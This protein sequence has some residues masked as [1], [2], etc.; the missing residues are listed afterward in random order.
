MQQ[1]LEA[2]IRVE[3]AL[4][5]IESLRTKLISRELR[6]SYF[7]SNSDYYSFYVDVLMQLHRLHPGDGYDRL[8]FE[9]SERG[10]AR[11]LLDLLNEAE[12]H[13]YRGADP[14]LLEREA[15]IRQQLDAQAQLR[16]KLLNGPHTPQQLNE[17]EQR[18]RELT[19]QY[20]QVEAEIRENSPKYAALTQPHPASVAEIQQQLSDSD[21]VLLEY[22]LGEER[23]YLWLVTPTTF[24]SYELPKRGEIE[25]V[26]RQAYAELSARVQ[27]SVKA[28]KE[29][30]TAAAALS[31]LLLG[32]VGSQLGHQRLVIVADGALNYIPFGALPEPL[33]GALDAVGS[34]TE[35]GAFVPLLVDHEV[36]QLPSASVLGLLR[37]ETASRQ[38][39]TKQVFVVADPVFSA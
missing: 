16:T 3:E 30:E 33:G 36:V 8:A 25:Q 4:A 21:T 2:R 19:T 13:I 34:Q 38:V 39:A 20:E 23:S 17:L 12:A 5:I 14:Q 22:A 37:R 27:S 31:N 18:L 10:K 1:L 28:D 15:A 35:K 24:A 6:T 7:S 11:S 9:A 26:A 32:K 29:H